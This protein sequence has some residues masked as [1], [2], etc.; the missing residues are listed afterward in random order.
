MCVCTVK[1]WSEI[2]HG[3][4]TSIFARD[5]SIFSFP[6]DNLSKCQWVSTKLRMYID[7][8]KIWFGIAN[9]QI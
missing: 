7:V 9:G 5:V 3:Q 8:V 6:D 4:I 1:V 2:A